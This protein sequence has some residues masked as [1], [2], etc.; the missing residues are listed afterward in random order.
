MCST[1]VRQCPA[2]RAHQVM[3]AAERL[4]RLAAE[5][6]ELV[7]DAA[8]SGDG[9]DIGSAAAGMADRDAALQG[10]I[11]EAEA[12]ISEVLRQ[13]REGQARRGAR[14]GPLCPLPL[15][16][17]PPARGAACFPACGSHCATT[18]APRVG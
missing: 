1:R 2:T 12:R 14:A 10:A 5:R 13:K 3:A 9:P 17:G 8:K 15:V 7:E 4:C 11:L 6:R 18:L 16:C